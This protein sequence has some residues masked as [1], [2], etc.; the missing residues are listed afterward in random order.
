M[1]VNRE[2]EFLGPR[3]RAS[4][5]SGRHLGGGYKDVKFETYLRDDWSHVPAAID[6]GGQW[7]C[8]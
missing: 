8:D 7:P 2:I 3:Q 1:P 6:G 5:A 4:V